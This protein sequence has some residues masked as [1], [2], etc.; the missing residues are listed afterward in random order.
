MINDC[1]RDSIVS[2][3]DVLGSPTVHGESDVQ[4]DPDDELDTLPDEEEPPFGAVPPP[5][6]D[7]N[8]TVEALTTVLL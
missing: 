7:V 3:S 2:E 1:V 5:E 6:L 4:P 8:G